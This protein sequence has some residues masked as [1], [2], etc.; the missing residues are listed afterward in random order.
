MSSAQ[1]VAIRILDKEF[2][3]NCPPDE[4]E[5]LLNSARHLDARMRDLR[6]GSKIVGMDRIAVMAA[7]NSTYELLQVQ[8]QGAKASVGSSDKLARLSNKID[9][10]LHFCRQL[11][12]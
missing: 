4:R 10:A 11:E 2:Q 1:T 3:I 5:A 6:D 8:D 9:D 12:I 7:L